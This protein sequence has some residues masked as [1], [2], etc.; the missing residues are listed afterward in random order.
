M[1]TYM[2]S[3]QVSLFIGVIAAAL[4]IFISNIWCFIWLLRWWTDDIMQRIVE[5]LSSIPNLIVVILFVL[6]FDR[7]F[8][9]LF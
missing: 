8:G 9:Q 2:E 6:L 5:I 7:Q 3:T 1:D 4:D